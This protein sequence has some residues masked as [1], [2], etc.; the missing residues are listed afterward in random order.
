LKPYK[1]SPH[2]EKPRV[3]VFPGEF[4]NTFEEELTLGDGLVNRMLAVHI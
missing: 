1:K 2:R 3:F 4:Y